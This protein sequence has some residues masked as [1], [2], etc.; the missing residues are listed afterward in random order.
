MM[1]LGLNQ[2]TAGNISARWEDGMLVTPTGIP[3]DRLA[4]DDLEELRRFYD[5][6]IAWTVTS[7]KLVLPPDW[8]EG[9]PVTHVFTRAMA[10]LISG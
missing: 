9:N 3:Y 6:E 1:A 5:S 10:A 7:V 2:G 4:A 8:A